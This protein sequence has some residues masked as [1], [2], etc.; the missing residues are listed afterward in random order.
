MAVTC[1]ACGEV[2]RDEEFCDR[3]NAELAYRAFRP[4]AVCRLEAL[5][6]VELT[7]EQRE[8]LSWPEASV[9][10]VP[11]SRADCQSALPPAWR[12]HWIAAEL[13]PRWQ[14][15][16]N[17]RMSRQAVCLP[18]CRVVAGEQGCWVLAEMAAERS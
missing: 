11:R 15:A 10:V 6:D 7:P 12:L 16:L 8:V 14:A 13:W 18:S 1:P 3:C 9:T 5:G 4:P 17:E 2:S